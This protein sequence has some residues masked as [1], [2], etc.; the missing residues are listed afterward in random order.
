MKTRMIA[1]ATACALICGIFSGCGKEKEKEKVELILKVPTLA[2]TSACDP[3]ITQAYD[4]LSKAAEDFEKN[5]TD[6]DVEINIKKFEFTN[7]TNAITGSYDTDNAV[8]ILYEGYF[9]M[10]TYIH[11]GRVVPLDD[12]I[13]DEI[14][15]DIDE[16]YWKMSSVNGKIYMMPFLSLQN[17]LI[18]NKELFRSAGLEE[19][20]SD[21]NIIQ[22]WSVDEWVY[23][24]DALADNLPDNQFPMMMYA[25]NDQGDTHIMT[26][27]RS[28]GS[29]FFDSK[30]NFNIS[31]DEGK[32]ALQWIAE[33]K[34]RGWFP[35]SCEALEI[36]DMVELFTNGQLAIVTANN[37]SIPDNYGIDAGY[38][39]FPS[40]DGTGL[41]TSFVTGFEVFDNG[42]E[43][44]IKVAKD[45]VKYIYEHEKWLDYEAGGIPANRSVSQ[46]YKDQVFMLEQFYENSANAVDFTANSPNWRGVRDVFYTHIR[47]LLMGKSPDDVARE[48]DE[49]CNAVISSGREQSI[50]HE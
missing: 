39:N 12:I 4:F 42:D 9:N 10:A 8:D 48:I 43:T 1:I 41:V 16:S 27:I 11:E 32:A 46:K 24:L 28:Q 34:E 7:E 49:E 18:Y 45:F 6:Y 50:L 17:I 21:E 2:M 38:V 35:L 3:D 15:G 23:I 14:R 29:G 19:F 13:T 37:A 26:L 40:L 30:G 20:V 5:Y 36:I 47:D 25:K 22:S 44:K 31:S 33:G